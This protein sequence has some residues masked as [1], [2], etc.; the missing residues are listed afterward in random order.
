[1]LG[2][3]GFGLVYLA[4]DEQLNRPV[5]IKV[6]HAKL[7]SKPEDTEAYLTEARTVAN[8]DHPNI[9]P[10]YDVG[11]TEQYPCFLVS[12]YIDG[13]A[14]AS[15]LKQS[16][17]PL[18]EAVELVAMVAEALHYA[19]KQGLVHR[20]IKPGN[21]LL[22]KSGKPF[23]ADFGLTLREQDVG[24][25]PR[26]LGTP[27]YMSPE[28]ARGEGHRVDGR[29]DIFSLGVVFYELLVGRR[30]F[31]GDSQDELLDQIVS[32][33]ARPPRQIDDRI[34]KELDRICLKAL[35]KRASERYS[36]ARDLADDLRHWLAG[37]GWMVAAKDQSD[38]ATRLSPPT[39]PSPS[40]LDAPPS[41]PSLHTPLTTIPKI[42]PKGLRSFDAHDADFFLELLPGPR[43][44]DGLPDSIRFWK[45]RIEETDADSTF[46]VGLIYGPS[47]CGKS[48]LVK[49]GLL[50]RLAKSVTAVYIEA[51]ADETVARL[52]KGLRRQVPDLPINLSLVDSLAALRRGRFL[53][54]GQKV[55]LVLDQFEQWL[56]AKKAE[57]NT[58]LAQALRQCDGGRVQSIVMVRDDFWLAVSRFL[59]ELE[60]RLIEG[61]NIALIDLFDVDHARK[62]L[63]AFGRAFGKLP[64]NTGDTTKDQQDFVKQSVAGL[65]EEGKVVCV[66]LALFAEMMKGKAWTPATLKEVGGTKGVGATFLEETFSSPAASP[67]H[68]Y[69]QKAARAVLK[70]LLSGSGTDIKGT[71]RSHTELLAASGYGNRPKDFDD[72]IRILDREIR[73]ITPTDPEGKDES[74]RM[75]DEFERRSDPSFVLHPPSSRYY[76]LTHDYLVH[77]LRDWLTRKQKET[78]RGRAELRLS[79]RA[80]AYEAKADTRF[81]PSWWEW[82]N[83]L[84]FTNRRNWTAPERR[85]MRAAGRYHGL[86]F[87]ALVAAVA[88][89]AVLGVEAYRRSEQQRAETLAETV[90]AARADGVPYALDNLRPL[91]RLAIS[92]LRERLDDETRDPVHR[93]HAAYALAD[94]GQTP[95]EFMIEAVPTVP[96]AEYRNL[97]AP[98]KHMKASALPELA[99]RAKSADDSTHKARYA[100][101]A[102]QLGDPQ[103]AKDCLTL[104]SDPI[105]RT[106]FIHAYAG[107]HGDVAAAAE[108]LR[109]NDNSTFRSGLCAAF[110]TVATEALDSSERDAAAKILME[111]YLQAPDGGTHAAACWAL[112]QW[113]QTLPAIK[114]TSRPPADRRWFVNG[115]GMTM[116]EIPAGK[117]IMG[118]PGETQEKDEEQ[119]AHKVTLAKPF[120]LCDREVTLEQFRRFIDD[121]EYP[122]T[123]KPPGWLDDFKGFEEHSPTPDCSVQNVNWF[124]AVLYCNW[125]SAREGRTR[126][127]RRTGEKQKIED[128]RIQESEQEC[129]V[130]RCDFTADGYRLP[131]EAE[132]EYA[133]RAVSSA[134][135]SF[136]SDEDLLPQYAWIVVNAKSRMWPGGLKLPNAFGL[137]DMQGNAREWCWDWYGKYSAAAVSDPT[138]PSDPGTRLGRVMRGGSVFDDGA[139][140]CRS[141]LRRFNPPVDR[142]FVTNGFRVLCPR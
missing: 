103:P 38:R 43:D 82:P 25:G 80:A 121:A 44:R 74:G 39:T 127:F 138:G 91:G 94:N 93:L 136:G 139:S 77:S 28:Q 49:A 17:L 97:V 60:V 30:P 125:L 55:L 130:W 11:S 16:R 69:H 6:P 8:L 84:T 50:P 116:V 92:F 100:I 120:L 81:V 72:L 134:A 115:Q 5:A 34:P 108:S 62:V 33:E 53:E 126:C 42:V 57:E 112:R 123:E 71:M 85:V 14:L 67:E 122:S 48:S 131:T 40:T 45:T 141:A 63:A 54:S 90:L 13:S 29:S 119:P 110:G 107:W 79:E 89:I 52:L 83:I 124:D 113:K 117:F 56:H 109:T 75:N 76:Q 128:Y 61:H 12:K 96:V 58:D 99:R 98:L 7:I 46:S 26:Y 87:T 4:Q 132:W 68:R 9:V 88:L 20:D 142:D 65:A 73:L 86:R 95:W 23:V 15:R 19:H 70:V 104:R 111:L 78:R 32:V 118:T 22:D 27:A 106:T 101:V 24:T 47:G 21:V 140:D 10:V 36:A 129:D 31:K 51:T 64:D 35:S 66:R 137:F 1:M 105:D 133:C 3:G 18:A 102:L 37:E 59:R 135:F 2:R 41:T 114:P